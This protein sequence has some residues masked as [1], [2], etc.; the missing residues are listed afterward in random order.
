MKFGGCD[1]SRFA[2]TYW[3]LRR[4]R[5][6]RLALMTATRDLQLRVERLPENIQNDNSFNLRQV[7][8]LGVHFEADF[9]LQVFA[10]RLAHQ[11]PQRH[12]DVDA[13]VVKAA[14]ELVGVL[15]PRVVEIETQVRVDS[16]PEIIV[17]HKDLRI[18]FTRN[19]ALHRRSCNT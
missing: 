3:R 18:V 5:L 2:V 13:L 8:V 12:F 11:L 10:A 16:D 7:D 15:L 6:W 14:V 19:P 9:S 4:W 17:H 1:F